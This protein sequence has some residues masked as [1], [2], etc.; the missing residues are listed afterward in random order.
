MRVKIIY[1]LG[2]E[3]LE[4]KINTFLVENEDKIEV[5]EIKWK[6]FFEHQVMIV[7]KLK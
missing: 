4:K 5:I 7:Y 2:N 1:S 6:V 3:G